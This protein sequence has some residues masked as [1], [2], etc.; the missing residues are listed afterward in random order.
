MLIQKLNQINNILNQLIKI[1]DEDISNIKE[2]KHEEVFKHISLKEELSK[3]FNTLKSEIDYILSQR[4]LPIEKI[5]S[6]EEEIEF[7]KFKTLLNEFYQKHKFFSK[8]SFTVTNFYNALLEQIKNKKPIT[9]DKKD[10]Q[11]PYM[12]LKA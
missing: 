8:L 2:A 4:N 12:K 9:Y 10:I 11:N 5:F 7:E 3:E 1:T 6:K